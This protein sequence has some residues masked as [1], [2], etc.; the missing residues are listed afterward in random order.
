MSIL[1][2]Y[3]DFINESSW[4]PTCRDFVEKMKLILKKDYEFFNK[5]DCTTYLP[6]SKEEYYKTSRKLEEVVGY[7]FNTE[8]EKEFR[9][10]T[11]EFIE[12]EIRGRKIK[13]GHEVKPYL[14]GTSDYGKLFILKY[15]KDNVKGLKNFCDMGC[16][17]GMVVNMASKIGYN[18]I[19]VELQEKRMK[20]AHEQLGIKVIYGDFFELDLSFLRN[21]DVIYLWRPVA[22][23]DFQVKLLDLIY[24][25]TKENVI[26]VFYG[27]DSKEELRNKYEVINGCEFET[28]L[29][30]K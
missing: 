20:P 17:T 7:N 25:N 4:E 10:F 18:A 27:N 12:E 28:I 22:G 6:I 5:I 24:N 26:I 11:H 13:Y 8:Q 23:R 19:G 9:K 15:L 14:Q 1:S 30:K 21:M 3:R 16:F 2:K 29:L